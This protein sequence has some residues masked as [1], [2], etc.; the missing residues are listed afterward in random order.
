MCCHTAPTTCCCTGHGHG[1]AGRRFFSKEEKI[2][3]LKKYAEDLEKEL[4]ET[5]KRVKSLQE[6]DRDHHCC[7]S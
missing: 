2:E 4:A 1:F 7:C 3:Q 6:D 5:K